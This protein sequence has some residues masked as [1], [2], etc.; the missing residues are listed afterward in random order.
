MGLSLI[1]LGVLDFFVGL[2]FGNVGH[3]YSLLCFPLIAIIRGYIGINNK[4]KS[5][6][7]AIFITLG[8]AILFFIGLL[9][10]SVMLLNRIPTDPGNELMTL[11]ALNQA[12]MLSVITCF[13]YF[14]IYMI[15]GT[16]SAFLCKEVRV[17]SKMRNSEKGKK[18]EEKDV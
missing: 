15:T 5:M 3:F 16:L 8:G 17:A 7:H 10:G 12:F 9:I 13:V 11:T 1:L 6:R 14:V 18:H 2:F 4:H